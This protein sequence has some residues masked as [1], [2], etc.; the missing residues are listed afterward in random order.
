M[1]AGNVGR[2]L[3]DLAHSGALAARREGTSTK[4]AR[5]VGTMAIIFDDLRKR[6]GSAITVLVVGASGNWELVAAI[7]FLYEIFLFVE[8]TLG[9]DSSDFGK[10]L[11]KFSCLC[12]CTKEETRSNCFGMTSRSLGG[13]PLLFLILIGFY[14]H[15]RGW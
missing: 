10:G 13:Q 8:E 3:A 5:P 6:F 15:W 11:W 12:T 7:F 2:T 14:I 9:R 1:N 4:F